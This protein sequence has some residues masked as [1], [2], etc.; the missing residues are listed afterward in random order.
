MFTTMKSVAAMLVTTALLAAPYTASAKPPPRPLMLLQ[1]T[2]AAT[3]ELC[4]DAFNRNRSKI[5]AL[6]R[7]GDSPAIA[8]LM[9]EG[10]CVQAAGVPAGTENPGSQDWW[11]VC[12]YGFRYLC[13]FGTGEPPKE[14]FS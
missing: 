5:E 3:P 7:R 11:I 12:R 10:G 13:I 6:Y 9:H 2:A 1:E 4:R 8:G 14:Y